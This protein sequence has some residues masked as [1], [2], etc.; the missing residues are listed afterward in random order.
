MFSRRVPAQDS[1]NDFSRAADAAHDRE[2]GLIDLTESNPT[3]CGFAYDPSLVAALARPASLLYEPMPQGMR[4]PREAIAA[5]Y[6]EIGAPVDPEHLLLASGTS[7]AYAHLFTLLANAGEEILV[8]APGYPLLEVLTGLDGLRVTPYPLARDGDAWGIDVDG[9]RSVMSRATRAVAVVSPN[10]PTGSF[11]K[12]TELAGLS[13]LCA[14]RDCALIVDEVFS[15]FAAGPDAKRVR[16]AVGTGEALTF[17]LNGLSKMSALPQMKLAW[18][19]ASGPARLRDE[20]LAR[21]AYI[22]DAFLSVSTP[23]QHAAPDLIA[24]RGA[25]QGQIQARLAA[26]MTALTTA[27]GGVSGGRVLAR[28][29]GWYAIVELAEGIDDEEVA[30]ALI[31]EDG[32][33][34]HPGY[35]Y[36]FDAGAHL[37]LSLLPRAEAFAEGAAR[38]ARRLG[39]G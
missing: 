1:T 15:D 17:V 31:D 12:K 33:L 2:D 32:V 35:F 34:A 7:E 8:P 13:R 28:E 10:N 39:R 14:E 18:I 16:T 25:I 11:L 21:L 4:A 36:D 30:L 6:A 38:I 19:H 23:V 20:S 29:G 27:L 37:V 5:Y 26:N 22:A 9:V 24:T 3:R